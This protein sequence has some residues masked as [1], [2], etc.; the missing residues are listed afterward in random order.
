MENLL[1]NIFLIIFVLFLMWMSF[2]YGFDKGGKSCIAALYNIL[3]SK[4]RERVGK[5]IEKA[6]QESNDEEK[7]LL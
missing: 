7:E 4:T 3:D 6:F 5:A 1:K 2:R